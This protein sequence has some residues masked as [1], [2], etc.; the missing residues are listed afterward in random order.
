[1][2]VLQISPFHI[3]QVLV[4]AANAHQSPSACATSIMRTYYTWQIFASPDKS[5]LYVPNG[6]WSL[7][8]LSAGIIVGCFPVMPRLFQHVAPRAHRIFKFGSGITKSSG[9]NQS[10]R[11]ELPRTDTFIKITNHFDKYDAGVSIPDVG[12]NPDA[13]IDGE[14][15]VLNELPQV[16]ARMPAGVGVPTKRDDLEY[17]L[18]GPEV[19]GTPV[20]GERQTV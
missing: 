7:A 19:L 10:A 16:Q 1:M 11:T 9:Y 20:N 8:E 15:Y 4:L 2:R 18:P 6:L 14:Q 17:G 12:T 3:I 13:H 5:Y